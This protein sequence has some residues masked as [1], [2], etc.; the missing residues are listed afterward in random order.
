MFWCVETRF[1]CFR[2]TTCITRCPSGLSSD[3][4]AIGSQ[5]QLIYFI[6][7][8]EILNSVDGKLNWSGTGPDESRLETEEL[9]RKVVMSEL[10]IESWDVRN[11]D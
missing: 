10:V 8:F 6:F 3:L 2:V 4:P 9:K 5:L 1:L 11:R 7:S